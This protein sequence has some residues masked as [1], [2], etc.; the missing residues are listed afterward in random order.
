MYRIPVGEAKTNLSI[1]PEVYFVYIH[2]YKT[3]GTYR[4][5][6]YIC[7]VSYLIHS[8]TLAIVPVLSPSA[9]THIHTFSAILSI[10]MSLT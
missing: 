2:Y 6:S 8:R 7:V 1:K 4:P 3:L 10:L 9:P 5:A